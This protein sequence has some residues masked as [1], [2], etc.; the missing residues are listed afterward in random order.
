[1]INSAFSAFPALS[2][3]FIAVYN[4]IIGLA[5]V[6]YYSI[7]EQDINDDQYKPAWKLLP[8]FYKE[9]KDLDL[10]SYKRYILWT[11]FGCIIAVFIFCTT[12]YSVGSA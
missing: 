7:F 9:T 1:M 10:L 6:V 5:L 2:Q 4:I 3:S 11:I 12:M 8:T